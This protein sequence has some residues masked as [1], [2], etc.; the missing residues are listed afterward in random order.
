[1]AHF[2]AAARKTSTTKD[3]KDHEGVKPEIGARFQGFRVSRF[4][5][6]NEK[7]QALGLALKP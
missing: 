1:M 3:T 6:I 2:R 4:Q 5:S 7:P